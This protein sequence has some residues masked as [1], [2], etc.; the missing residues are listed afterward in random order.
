MH[1]KYSKEFMLIIVRAKAASLDAHVGCLYPES[2]LLAMIAKSDNVISQT[3]LSEG[4]KVFECR[5]ELKKLLRSKSVHNKSQVIDLDDMNVSDDVSKCVKRA[6]DIC[7]EMN[8]KVIGIRHMFMAIMELFPDIK[9]IFEISGEKKIDCIFN[10]IKEPQMAGPSTTTKK[11]GNKTSSLQQYCIDM[12]EKASKNEYDP[13][14]AR[15]DEIEEVITTLC[16]RNKSNPLLIGDA[17][18]GK[19][20]VLEGISQ[21]I[22]ALTVPKILQGCKIYSLSMTTMVAGTQYRGQF[23]ERIQDLIKEA[24]NDPK[25]ILFIDELHTIIGAGS[26]SGNPMDASNILKPALARNLKCIG[27]TTYEE[28]KKHIK[29]DHALSRRFGIINIDEPNEQQIKNILLSVRIKLEQHHDCMITEDAINTSIRLTKRY[30][31]DRRFPDKA[32]DCL[33]CACA[34]YAWEKGGKENKIVTGKDIAMIVSKQCNIPIEVIMWDNDKRLDDIQKKLKS[35][36]IG[37]PQAI[38]NICRVLK[39]AYSGVR[40]PNRP[41]GVL[42][43]GGESGTGKTYTAKELANACFGSSNSLIRV[44]MSEYSESH[45]TSRIIGAPHGYVGFKDGDILVDKIKRKPY[46]VLLLDEIE[47]AHSNVLKLFLQVMSDGTLTSASGDNIDCRNVILIMTGNFGMNTEKKSA[48]GFNVATNTADKCKNTTDDIINYCKRTY[49][50]DFVNRVDAFV[51]YIPPNS[52]DIA[53]ISEI[54]LSEF[55]GRINNQNIKIVF[56]KAIPEW[57][58]KQCTMEH[59]SNAMNIDRIVTKYMEPQI[60]DSILSLEDIDNYIVTI[61]I[62]LDSDKISTKI[63]KRKKKNEKH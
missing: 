14:I 15:E 61:T 24:E 1:D 63:N 25:V 50:T 43:L 57:I 20:A 49:G 9:E 3:L 13:I 30:I 32:I 36:I 5:T 11:K 17:G 42:V 51:P 31:T 35:R 26:S 55:A 34:K 19:T 22:V 21:R 18:V 12:T 62:M 10:Q 48:M 58:A 7:S 29:D 6:E 44:D 53:K 27:A 59:G 28:Y 2:F 60:A 4:F 8:E 23:E 54:N 56:D 38:D 33:D 41:I 52:E 39:N 46:C 16:R 40:N 47:K 37:Q 45:S